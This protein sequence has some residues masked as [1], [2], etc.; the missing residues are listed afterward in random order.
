MCVLITST[1]LL[2]VHE[3]IVHLGG[4]HCALLHG[5]HSLLVFPC[6]T[7]ICDC[8]VLYR[9]HGICVYYWSFKY[10]C[11]AKNITNVN[12]LPFSLSVTSSYQTVAHTLPTQIN[13]R[14]Y[15]STFYQT[16]AHTLP[17]HTKY[18]YICFLLLSNSRPHFTNSH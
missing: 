6:I 10:I 8:V 13:M 16:V 15:V 3:W 2:R 4:D 9:K 17:T 7:H 14:I 1:T 11:P 12:G 18:E 5:K